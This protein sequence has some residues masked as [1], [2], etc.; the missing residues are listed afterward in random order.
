MNSLLNFY[1]ELRRRRVFS[2]VAL[3][4][5]AA[6]AVIQVG[7]L[8]IDAGMLSGLSLRNLFVLAIIGFPLALIAGWFYD[9]SRKGVVRTAPVGADKL[10]SGTLQLK[11]YLLLLVLAVV[12]AGAY[13]YVHTPPPVNKSIAVMPFENRGNDPEN[14]SFAL[15]IH[16]D[17]M[18][19]LYIFI[20]V[21]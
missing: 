17:L 2:V 15:G 10:F 9:I 8:A 5:V 12:W 7:D 3:Y 11:D 4:M 16:D 6:W 14:A 20:A 1:R 13:V 18:T 19:Q 21:H